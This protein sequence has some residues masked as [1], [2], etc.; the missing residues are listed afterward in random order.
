MKEREKKNLPVEEEVEKKVEGLA[1]LKDDALGDKT[2]APT[3]N[4]L[5]FTTN[6]NIRILLVIKFGK[7]IILIPNYPF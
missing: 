7:T 4:S 6:T 5:I 2:S 3:L 1:L